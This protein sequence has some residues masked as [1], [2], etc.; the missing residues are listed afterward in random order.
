[1]LGLELLAHGKCYGRLV[2]G[3]ICG[4]GHHD[5]IADAEQEQAAFWQIQSHLT[6]DFV[7]ALTEEFFTNGA[8]AT[9]PGLALHQLLIEH[10]SEACNVNS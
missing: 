6:N 3:L 1:M 9:F 2:E 4:D 8:D 5:F 10:L 7:E